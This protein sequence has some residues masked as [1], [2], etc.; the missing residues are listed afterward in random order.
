MRVDS[1]FFAQMLE[2]GMHQTV[3]RRAASVHGGASGGSQI[4]DRSV[5]ALVGGD[6]GEPCDEPAV[7]PPASRGHEPPPS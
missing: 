3:R 2:Q 7:W 5:A 4:G 1:Q 6:H